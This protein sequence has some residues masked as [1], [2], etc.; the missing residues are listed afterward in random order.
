MPF[1]TIKMAVPGAGGG[2]PDTDVHDAGANP[3]G[4]PGDGAHDAGANPAGPGEARETVS[5]ACERECRHA[6]LAF[7]RWSGLCVWPPSEPVQR[8]HVCGQA[9]RF[10]N[11]RAFRV[12]ATTLAEFDDTP[13]YPDTDTTLRVSIFPVRFHRTSVWRY[14]TEPEGWRMRQLAM[15][16][17]LLAVRMQVPDSV[18]FVAQ[19]LYC[20][21]RG[22]RG[23]WSPAAALYTHRGARGNWTREE[24]L[25]LQARVR[26]ARA[27]SGPAPPAAASA[28]RPIFVFSP[29]SPDRPALRYSY[30][31][32]RDEN[33]HRAVNGRIAPMR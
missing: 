27:D 12:W 23:T 26:A 10:P 28:C 1:A 22:A 14:P 18:Q 29:A 5:D 9:E 31:L 32:L 25:E 13:C 16:D 21:L 19:Q 2:A 7:E 11:I 15:F 6:L 24:F 20:M 17:E 4:A 3:A 8:G 33:W 30:P